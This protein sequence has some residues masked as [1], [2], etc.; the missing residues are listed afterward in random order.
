MCTGGTSRV[1]LEVP[2]SARMMCSLGR[3]KGSQSG[4]ITLVP[5][6]SDVAKPVPDIRMN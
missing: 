1:F 4:A 6:P 5:R 2:S 3:E